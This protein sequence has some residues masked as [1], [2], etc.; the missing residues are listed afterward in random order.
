MKVNVNDVSGCTKE[1]QV[2]VPLETVQ[3]KVGDIYQRISKEAK[4]PGFRKGK[5]P[6][7]A[8]RKQYKSAVRE[9]MVNHQLPEFFREVLT[10]NNLQPVAQPQVTHLQFE[11]DAPMKFVATV[12]IKPEFELKEYKGIPIKKESTNVTE[13]EVNK[14]LDGMRDQMAQFAPIE[15]R[16]SKMDDLLVIDF[17]GKIEGKTFEGGKAS[18]YTVLLGGKNLLKDFEDQLIGVKKGETKTFTITFPADY[19]KKDV[20]EKPAEFTVTLKEI[21]EKKLPVVD[22]AFAKDVA[23]VDT[24]KD[25]REKLEA[26]IKSN[27]EVDQRGKMIEQ[28]GEKLMKDHPFDIPLSLIHA[29]QQRLIQQGVERMRSQGID[30]HTL[31]DDQK[32]E[33]VEKLRPVAERNVHMALIVEKIEAVEKVKCEKPDY[34]AY[35]EKVSKGINQSVETLRNYIHQKGNEESVKGM[36][37]YE[38][39]LDLLISSAKVEAA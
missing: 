32:K 21:K 12:E 38:K 35:L 10:Q 1:V 18:D 3:S 25:L 19:F 27:K 33:F 29:E 26:Q 7:E 37:Q 13:E 31:T 34:E 4:L 14:A 39:T 8:I 20:A 6:L 17:E 5:A 36:I 30:A 22:D 24:V 28:I 2:E 15:D 11:E 9:E 23:Q 16:A